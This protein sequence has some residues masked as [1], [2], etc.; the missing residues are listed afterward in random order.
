M[1]SHAA[2]AALT[3][4]DT[5]ASGRYQS[6]NDPDLARRCVEVEA[7]YIGG[8]GLPGYLNNAQE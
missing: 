7:E 8:R 1:K 2:P 3:T 5:A 6:I 4:V